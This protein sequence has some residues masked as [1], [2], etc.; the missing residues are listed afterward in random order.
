VPVLIQN[1]V[2][3]VEAEVELLNEGPPNKGLEGDRPI[4]D[5][6]DGGGEEETERFR[7]VRSLHHELAPLHEVGLLILKDK[8]QH[9][10][11]IVVDLL[12]ST[13]DQLVALYQI[14][15]LI[16]EDHLPVALPLHVMS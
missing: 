15:E 4:I 13:F 8:L 14:V 10:H 9:F 6:L 11:P 12:D 7:Q 2:V 1:E 16:R 5:L 3:Y